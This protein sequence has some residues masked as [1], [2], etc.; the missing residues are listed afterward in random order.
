MAIDAEK[1]T[2]TTSTKKSLGSG[3]ADTPNQPGGKVPYL[4]T[5]TMCDLGRTPVRFAN[6]VHTKSRGTFVT[7]ST[8]KTLSPKPSPLYEPRSM[9]S[10]LIPGPGGGKKRR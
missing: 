8:Q 10:P 3:P 4:S 7:T 6:E 9:E 1:N 2:V 5:S